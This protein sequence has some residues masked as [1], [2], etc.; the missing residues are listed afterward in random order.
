MRVITLKQPWATLLVRGQKLIETRSWTPKCLGPIL[1][2]AS[3]KFDK[4]DKERCKKYP[5]NLFISDANELP[6]GAII[7]MVNI[8]AV[9]K[10][11]TIKTVDHFNNPGVHAGVE[12]TKTEAAFGDYSP[13]RYGWLCSNAAEFPDPIPAKGQLGIWKYDGPVEHLM[14]EVMP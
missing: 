1:V 2:H 14:K 8:D 5:F 9:F 6:L 11:E 4:A 12:I 13:N 10:S 7:G 3:A